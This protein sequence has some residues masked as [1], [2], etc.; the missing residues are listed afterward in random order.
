[1]PMHKTDAF[2]AEIAWTDKEQAATD[3]MAEREFQLLYD[4]TAQPILAYLTGVTGRRDVAEDVLQ[5]TFLALAR[6]AG[7]LHHPDALPAWLHRTARNL[8][9]RIYLRT[10]L[11]AG[12]CIGCN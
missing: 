2:A 3:S 6:Q 8:G 7:R 12:D 5:A 10:A 4:A 11:E 1:M 9:L